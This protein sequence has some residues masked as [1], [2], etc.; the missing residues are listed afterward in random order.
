MD[1]RVAPEK[2]GV[3]RLRDVPAGAYL[4]M[5]V[6]G[7]A[8]LSELRPLNVD[9]PIP[10]YQLPIVPPVEIG[11]RYDVSGTNP[12][13]NALPVEG[14][15]INLTRT[16]NEVS[17]VITAER[18]SEGRLVFKGVG[19]GSYYVTTDSPPGYYLSGVT[20]YRWDPE[21]PLDPCTPLPGARAVGTRDYRFLDSHGHLDRTLPL[22]VPAIIPGQVRCLS[23][24]IMFGRR[25]FGRAIDR[26]GLPVAGALVVGLPRIVWGT[27]DSKVAFTPPDRYLTAITDSDGR[28]ILTGVPPR[29]EYKLLAFEDLDTNL[30]YDPDLLNHFPNRDLIEIEIIAGAEAQAQALAPLP[31]NLRSVDSGFIPLDSGPCSSNRQCVLKTIPAGETRELNMGR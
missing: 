20:P 21:N 3:V 5:A 23:V 1:F 7:R 13:A 14:T 16:G 27:D 19:P 17:H 22:I 11:V 4:V 29:M 25:F 30:I 31:Q 10:D 6:S 2:D 18:D 15:R 24:S 28:F 8:S 12:G 9:G 26:S